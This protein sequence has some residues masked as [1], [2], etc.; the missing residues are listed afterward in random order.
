M[1]APRSRVAMVVPPLSL[2]PLSGS[3]CDG[4]PEEDLEIQVAAC[5]SSVQSSEKEK[6]NT[7]NKAVSMQLSVSGHDKWNNVPTMFITITFQFKQA[8][9]TISMLSWGNQGIMSIDLSQYICRGMGNLNKDHW[10]HRLFILDGPVQIRKNSEG[11]TFSATWLDKLLRS[12][13]FIL[14]E[15]L[16]GKTLNCVRGSLKPAGLPS[17]LQTCINTL[18]SYGR[19]RSRQ[20]HLRVACLVS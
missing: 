9:N 12:A 18:I 10:P 20:R 17:W 7:C 14:R 16:R 1:R 13:E 3:G 4:W 19:S 11:Y 15:E 8:K 5:F 6:K 2:E